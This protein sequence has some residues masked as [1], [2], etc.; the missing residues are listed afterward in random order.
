MHELDPELGR[1]LESARGADDPTPQ[2]R[3]R[4]AMAVAART[5]VGV[6]VGLTAGM[7]AVQATQAATTSGL[8]APATGLGLT[9]KVVGALLLAVGVGALAIPQSRH[10]VLSLVR[11]PAAPTESI[12]APPVPVAADSLAQEVA[13]LEQA[14]RALRDG[15]GEA[16]LALLDQHARRFPSGALRPESLAARV[17]ALCRLHRQDQ[18][19]SVA[20]AFLAE[21]PA[22]PLAPQVRASC[23]GGASDR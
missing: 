8:A 17:M 1:L 12:A 9:A 20:R 15:R 14:Q 4:V 2:N 21:A 11:P 7:G 3:A 22:S 13:L 16:A 19:R 18:A 5:G 10:A 6:G 23:A